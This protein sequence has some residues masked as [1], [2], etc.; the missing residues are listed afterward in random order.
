MAINRRRAPSSQIS[1][2]KKLSGHLREDDYATLIGGETIS[3]TQKG[4]VL[5][6][7][8]NLYSVKSGKKWQVF[9]Y[10][11][12]RIADSKNL[13]ILQPCLDAFTKDPQQYFKD[14]IK[15]IEFKEAY[16]KEYGRAKAKELPNKV[17]INAL[18]A[19]EYIEAKERLAKSTVSVRDRLKDKNVLRGFLGEALF[20]NDEVSF[21]AIK[22]TTYKKDDFFKVFAKEDVLDILSDQLFPEVS[23]AGNVPED[24]NVSAQK[25]LLCYL[26]NNGKSKNIVEIEIRNDSDVHYRQVRFNMYSKD[27]L[28]L[29]LERQSPLPVKEVFNN[30]K[31]YGLAIELL[32]L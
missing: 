24:Y 13:K 32:G 5:D 12:D 30:V 18:G 11:Y 27:A 2:E 7:K 31:V 1:R 4:D 10:V 15:C 28:T 22:D 6:K 17:V 25:T 20:N 9:L 19:N 16:V 14:R 8:G 21:L 26:R 23:K 29:L 3:G